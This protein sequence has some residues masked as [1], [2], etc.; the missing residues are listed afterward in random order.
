MIWHILGLLAIVVIYYIL[1]HY[2]WND[3]D[4]HNHNREPELKN[5]EE[6]VNYM[7]EAISTKPLRILGVNLNLQRMGEFNLSIRV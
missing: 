7:E 3:G 1:R 4:D 6:N 2:L 5:K